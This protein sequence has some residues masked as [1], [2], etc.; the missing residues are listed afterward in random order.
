MLNT[1]CEYCAIYASR[2]DTDD[3]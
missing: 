2:S 1:Y 3:L